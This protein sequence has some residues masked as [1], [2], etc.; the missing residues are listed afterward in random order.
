[1]GLDGQEGKLCNISWGAEVKGSLLW[2]L[3]S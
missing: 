1:M 3:L 2:A